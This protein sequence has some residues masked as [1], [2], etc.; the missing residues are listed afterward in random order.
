[1]DQQTASAMPG[2]YSWQIDGSNWV[3]V[4]FRQDGNIILFTDEGICEYCYEDDGSRLSDFFDSTAIM[5]QNVVH[6]GGP[7]PD[8]KPSWIIRWDLGGGQPKPSPPVKET[9]SV[10][11]PDPVAPV[12]MAAS[13]EITDIQFDGAE[14]R[15]EADEYVEITNSADADADLSG[16]QLHSQ[17]AKQVFT[18]P[19]GTVVAAGQ[20]VRVYTNQVH[21]E[22]GGF[23]FKSSRAIWNNRG[24][25]AQ[26]TDGS[27]AVK[28][29]RAYG[30]QA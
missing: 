9:T 12:E 15:T 29:R 16:W 6:D 8:V 3:G 30:N 10:S 13:V 14:T 26:L 18:F 27:G 17:G 24:D 5:E 20:S 11:P 7:L 4:G 28:A 2:G 22:S 19:Q 21:P 23:S 25:I 1:M